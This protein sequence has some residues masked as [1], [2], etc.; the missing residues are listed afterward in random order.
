[1]M[2]E[3]QLYSPSYMV[4][5]H[6]YHKSKAA[7]ARIHTCYQYDFCKLL[8]RFPPFSFKVQILPSIFYKHELVIKYQLRKRLSP[9]LSVLPSDSIPAPQPRWLLSRDMEQGGQ[10]MPTSGMQI[11]GTVQLS[12]GFGCSTALPSCSLN[13]ADSAWDQTTYIRN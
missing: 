1:M 12:L 8:L 3:K 11:P 7:L 10:R 5:R 9:Q 2:E 13:Q 4:I 6:G